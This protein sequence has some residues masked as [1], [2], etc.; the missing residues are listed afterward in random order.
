M[1]LRKL[2]VGGYL[3]AMSAAMTINVAAASPQ[4]SLSVTT[5]KPGT[6]VTISGQGFPSGQIVALY[7][8]SPD[9]YIG[10][11]GAVVQPDGSFQFPF[12]WPDNSWDPSHKVNPGTPGPHQVCADTS[13]PGSQQ[14]RA[15]KA[16]AEFIA[17][18]GPSPTPS[19][20]ASPTA[21]SKGPGLTPTSILIVIGVMVVVGA[22]TC[23]ILRRIGG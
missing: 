1:N 20:R 16:C 22:V 14:T 18:P 23:F 13:W 12:Q 8:D 2:A 15:V 5:G 3:A 9:P 6:N 11:P 7:I 10:Q 19:P 4:L 17:Q 21:P